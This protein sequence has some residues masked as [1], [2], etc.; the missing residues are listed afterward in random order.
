MV[1]VG[2]PQFSHYIRKAT[3]RPPPPSHQVARYDSRRRS[4]PRTC[5][6]RRRR[7][8]GTGLRRPSRTDQR[9]VVHLILCSSRVR[10]LWVLCS[11]CACHYFRLGCLV[12]F[13]VRILGL[14]PRVPYRVAQKR[15][16]SDLIEGA[17][18][19]KQ[20]LRLDRRGYQKKTTRVSQKHATKHPRGK[21]WCEGSTH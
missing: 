21:G 19:R 8:I 7:R 9:L 10:V 2:A 5:D 18:T 16:M 13:R 20:R 6:R 1:L 15:G 17:K 4:G 11:A 12:L 14:V 3:Q